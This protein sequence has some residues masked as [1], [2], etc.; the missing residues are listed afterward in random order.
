MQTVDRESRCLGST[1]ARALRDEIEG[2]LDAAIAARLEL[3]A[4]PEEAER[5]AVAAFGDVRA[6]VRAIRPPGPES[7]FDRRFFR[8][9]C[10]GW[11]L[12]TLTG[13]VGWHFLPFLLPVTSVVLTLMGLVFLMVIRESVRARRVQALPVLAMF[14]IFVILGAVGQAAIALPDHPQMIAMERRE[15]LRYLGETQDLQRE[16]EEAIQNYHRA[17]REYQMGGRLAPAKFREDQPKIRY[18][19]F[20]SRAELDQRWKD[21]DVRWLTSAN[22]LTA[23]FS[24]NRELYAERLARPWILDTG[25]WLGV[26]CGIVIY[27]TVLTLAVNLVSALMGWAW[28][29]IRR[30]GQTA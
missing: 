28:R 23:M 4:S 27:P 5:E 11:I 13:Y 9:V 30:R 19:L 21:A 8:R 18:E 20:E 29:T 2:H 16:Y 1:E 15:A 10:G 22:Q 6:I 26:S 24:R 17:R 14:P 7:W 25:A 12:V 3:G